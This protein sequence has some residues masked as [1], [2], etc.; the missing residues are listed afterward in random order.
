M[1]KK[2]QERNEPAPKQQQQ[3]KVGPQKEL[4]S[5]HPIPE[6]PRVLRSKLVS[7]AT[8]ANTNPVESPTKAMPSNQ[9]IEADVQL[10]QQASVSL[11]NDQQPSVGDNRTQKHAGDVTD[12][13]ESTQR[14][15]IMQ[16]AQV[17]ARATRGASQSG[18]TAIERATRSQGSK[19]LSPGLTLGPTHHNRVGRPS[20]SKSA[21]SK[22]PPQIDVPVQVPIYRVDDD[23]S[24]MDQHSKVL[25]NK[26]KDSRLSLK[27]VWF[28]DMA[29]DL[30]APES[31]LFTVIMERRRRRKR[32]VDGSAHEIVKVV[33]SD[34]WVRVR[35][36]VNPVN[37]RVRLGL[38]VLKPAFKMDFKQAGTAS[39][40]EAKQKRRKIM[41]E[42][43]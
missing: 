26:A 41:L 28:L 18:G 11:A 1:P 35:V 13:S 15:R 23:S 43:W 25:R 19:D 16:Q 6:Q 9:L 37:W 40:K 2:Y 10:I 42:R 22:G 32:N 31:P 24:V 39:R 12:R 17:E 3:H 27:R 8:P 21:H 36:R 30:Q 7:P 34:K 29:L 14:I 4:N 5:L 38:Q 20:T 33:P